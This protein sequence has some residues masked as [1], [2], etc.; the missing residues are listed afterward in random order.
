[1]FFFLVFSA[2][3]FFFYLMFLFLLAFLLISDVCCYSFLY[4]LN[5]VLFFSCCISISPFILHVVIRHLLCGGTAF[6]LFR[7]SNIGF[8]I[9]S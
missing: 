8:R 9:T 7:N 3:L 5:Y 4:F 2:F 6:S 1:M